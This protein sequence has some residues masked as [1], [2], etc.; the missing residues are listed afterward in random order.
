MKIETRR[1]LKL[2]ENRTD[3]IESDWEEWRILQQKTHLFEPLMNKNLWFRIKVW[4]Q[5]FI[6]IHIEINRLRKL[7][8]NP[9]Y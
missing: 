3:V 4:E 5:R 7:K 8:K 1:I 9:V 6:L 2:K